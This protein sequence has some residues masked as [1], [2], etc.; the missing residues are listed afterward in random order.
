M[1]AWSK[2]SALIPEIPSGFSERRSPCTVHLSEDTFLL[3]F[4]SLD[5]LKRSHTFL[6]LMVVRDGRIRLIDKPR[7]AIV[8]GDLGSFDEAGSMGSCFVKSNNGLLYLYYTGWQLL[9][10]VPFEFSIGRTI[11]NTDSLIVVR[12]FNGPVLGKNPCNPFL[13]GS[14]CILIE[15]GLW[16]M[17]YT[18]GILWKET[19]QVR[20]H[21]YT[22]GYAISNDGISWLPQGNSINFANDFE[23][24]IARPTVSLIAGLYLMWYSY[25]EQTNIN[26][27]RIGYAT[28]MDG[29]TW[30]RYDNKSGIDVSHNGWD[31]E[32]VCYPQV[33]SHNGI[34]YMLYNGNGYGA[35]GFGY[36]ISE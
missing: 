11:V 26:T 2:V 36:A 21:Y 31:S 9:K 6:Q 16:R 7:V 19:N 13:N 27:Y 14:P 4:T 24:A 30:K 17:W 22:V 10:T 15:N 1:I 35:S 23:Y 32:M 33:F 29:I 20:N 25:R 34:H 5:N 3:S 12:E 8:P 28:S 18:T